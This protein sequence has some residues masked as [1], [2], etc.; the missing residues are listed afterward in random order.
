MS[1]IDDMYAQIE[2][3]QKIVRDKDD[4]GL[5][6]VD[7][8]KNNI[9][10]INSSLDE[11]IKHITAYQASLTESHKIALTGLQ[12]GSVEYER[13]IQ[14]YARAMENVSDRIKTALKSQSDNTKQATEVQADYYKEL[15]ERIGEY[16]EEVSQAVSAVTDTL[17]ANLQLQLDGLNEQLD[18][19]NEKYE[20]AQEQREKSV[21]KVEELEERLRN[22]TG[23]TAAALRVINRGGDGI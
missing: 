14:N 7:A 11:Y 3:K 13:E 20:Q 17:N 15:L 2:K 22:A 19:I 6:D 1:A 9:R 10:E 16:A 23:S 8:T 21:Q 18:I 5:I 4:T 12:K